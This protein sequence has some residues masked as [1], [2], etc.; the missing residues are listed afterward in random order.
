[1]PA[2]GKRPVYRFSHFEVDAQDLE[3]RK[4][5]VRIKLQEQPFR[6]LE[7]LLQQPG[8]LVT[9]EELHAR[10]WPDRSGGVRDFRAAKP[11]CDQEYRC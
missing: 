6:L 7:A 1:M 11:C 5:S 4:H 2:N 10:L 9:R 8:T 3:L